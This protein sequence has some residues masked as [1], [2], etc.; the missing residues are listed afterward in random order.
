[1]LKKQYC[2]GILIICLF[3]Y[4]INPVFADDITYGN[5]YVE[6]ASY[7]AYVCNHTG[8]C[9]TTGDIIFAA[10]VIWN[11]DNATIYYDSRND[12]WE[13][14]NLT[15]RIPTCTPT[16]FLTSTDGSTFTCAESE[17]AVG[18]GLINFS[19]AYNAIT[20]RYDGDNYSTA[21]ASVTSALALKQDED[22]AWKDIN[23]TYN[24]TQEMIEAINQSLY[25]QIKVDWS[26]I[27]NRFI[28]AVSPAWFY[29]TG[30]TLTFNETKHNE[31]TDERITL[32]N[33]SIKTYV[34]D[35]NASQTAYTDLLNVT[36]HNWIVAQN[37][38]DNTVS[39]LINYFTKSQIFTF[40]EDNTTY[41]N[42]SMKDYTDLINRS[43]QEYINAQ[44]IIFNTSMKTYADSSNASQIGYTDAQD[45]IYNDSMVAHVDDNYYNITEIDNMDLYN[46]SEVND[47]IGQHNASMKNYVDVQDD[48]YNASMVDYYDR[49]TD[50]WQLINLTE[51]IPTCS[52]TQYLTSI[53]GL[54]FSCIESGEASDW[55]RANFSEAY[56]SI[57]DRWDLENETYNT[58]QDMINAVNQTG[59]FYDIKITW[60][61][62]IDKF[63]EAVDNV[64]INMDGTTATF[65]EAKLK[66][67]IDANITS[68]NESQNAYID[69]QDSNIRATAFKEENLTNATNWNK[70]GSDIYPSDLSGNVGIGTSSPDTLLDVEDN[71]V[72]LATIQTTATGAEYA[73]LDVKSPVGTWGLYTGAA[74]HTLIAGDFGIHDW[75]A[76]VYR[77]VIKDDGR[78][79]IG[80]SNPNRNLDIEGTGNVYMEIHSTDY[81]QFAI[82]SE[83]RG[84]VIYDDT[85][86]DYRMVIQ[87]GTGNVGIGTTSP[88]EKLEVAGNIN[89]NTNSLIWDDV[90]SFITSNRVAGRGSYGILIDS[91]NNDAGAQFTIGKD[92][93]TIGGQIELFRVEEGGNVGIGT[94]TPNAPLEIASTNARFRLND[95]DGTTFQVS[96]NTNIFSIADVSGG[97]AQI[98]KIE[99]GATANSIYIKSGGNV[100]I[101]NTIPNATLHVS[102]DVI[103]DNMKIGDVTIDSQSVYQPV[104]GTD[105][106]LVLYLPFNTPN[107]STQY[108]RSPYGNDGTQVGANCNSTNGKYGVGCGFDGVDDY[109]DVTDDA[110]L[111]SD[112]SDLTISA[113]IKL[114]A[115]ATNVKHGIISKRGTG[116][117]GYLLAYKQTGGNN[118]L[119]YE[120]YDGS[121]NPNEHSDTNLNLNQWY[122]IAITREPANDLTT[123]YLNGVNDGAETVD[124]ADDISN[125]GSLTIGYSTFTAGD[126]FNGTIDEVMI[127]KRALSAEEIRTHY[128]RG[129]GFG[130]S[131]A[132][133]A[134]KFRI[135]NTSGDVTFI[136]TDG[137]VGIGTPTPSSKLHVIG[138]IKAEK[139]NFTENV[140]VPYIFGKTIFPIVHADLVNKE[141]VDDAVSS[142]AFDFFFNDQASDISGHFNMTES[143]LDLPETTLT[144]A[145]LS[146]TGTFSI[147]NWTTL[148]GQPEFNELRKGVYG[149]HVHLGKSGSRTIAITP[150][151]YNISSDGTQRKLLVTFETSEEL[152]T[153]SLVYNLHGVMINDTILND[154]DRLNLELEAVVSSAGGGTTITVTLEGTTDSHLAV[155][156]STNAFE[157]IYVR[158]DGTNELTRNWNAGSFDI[159]AQNLFATSSIGIGTTSPNYEL[160]VA[161]QINAS[162][163]NVTGNIRVSSLSSCDTIDTDSEGNF[164]CGTDDDTTYTADETNI[165]LDGT[166]F[167][168]LQVDLAELDNSVSAF[169][170]NKVSN[171]VNYF[172]KTET[173]EHIGNNITSANESSNAK[174]YGGNVTGTFDA[175]VLNPCANGEI[176]KYSTTGKW[177]CSADNTGGAPDTSNY[178]NKANNDTANY[179]TQLSLNKSRGDVIGE[180]SSFF[181]S[182][183]KLFNFT[184]AYDGRIDRWDV[185][186][187]TYSQ[188]SDLTTALDDNYDPINSNPTNATITITNSQVSDFAAGVVANEQNPTNS[189]INHDGL[190]NFDLNEHFT[191]SS[192]EGILWKLSNFTTAFGNRLGELWNANNASNYLR[193]NSYL[194]KD[195]STIIA[196]LMQNDTINRSLYDLSQF[197]D[198]LTHTG[199]CSASNSCAAVVYGTNTT[200]VTSQSMGGDVGGTVGVSTVDDT[201]CTGSTEYLDGTGTCDDISGVYVQASDW[202]THDNYPSACT[203][204]FVRGLGD[205][206]TCA[207]VDSAD[208]AS[209]AVKDDEIDYSAVTLADF[210]NDPKFVS[211]STDVDFDNVTVRGNMSIGGHGIRVIGD[212]INW[213]IGTTYW[214]VG[215]GC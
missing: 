111:D 172:T 38:I 77:F 169:I 170:T 63:I 137:N 119:Y 57:G 185:G 14:I 142:T 161:G 99:A 153:D 101:G 211:N 55:G 152:T 2:F 205:S 114:A 184:K 23:E 133:T 68:A 84:F 82:G 187:E 16:Q 139:G 175:L 91:D 95:T 109:I 54:A 113:W 123:F 143:D 203:N 37:Y 200:Y 20:D 85:T 104:Y 118:R 46:G 165:T 10:S 97:G 107:G 34:D 81:S 27:L 93:T 135:V 158:R 88:S 18:W 98:F 40:F 44:D 140:S 21:N 190:L 207:T 25:Y 182:F 160:D 75:D 30:T 127:Y 87:N 151:L 128:L 80:T 197:N 31:T 7:S 50:R 163:V 138:D 206:L 191:Y 12:R 8:S 210:T 186:N 145:S 39:D 183:W 167:R 86:N 192:I 124:N 150:K 120:A 100:G 202:S 193:D 52:A 61:N 5:S 117:L 41:V 149:V 51:R 146:S 130:A 49:R 45:V 162:A 180:D 89:L 78:V 196:E 134:D 92:S 106:D 214:A 164:K 178:W 108:D 116:S 11:E 189:T 209:N 115:D 188:E 121:N 22:S 1:M 60:S 155:E 29:M 83:T 17:G 24:T 69:A 176:Y 201:K 19:E 47:S 70:T 110:S 147:F 177:V 102:G 157:K 213:T 94:T 194:T 159:T 208:I 13:L 26:N 132:I 73:G 136:V 141:Y 174:E 148:S 105:D 96:S 43:Q 4:L 199:N 90:N 156:T 212:C 15:E 28:T 36:Q 125:D 35:T 173:S 6:N 48:I 72:T 71:A 59:L 154:G 53:D 171:L 103:A 181:N 64:W 129:K 126:Y 179:L 166:V 56:D 79:G 62:I 195:N 3:L 42:D 198:D 67:Q 122:H 204:Q 65:N 76:G 215:S 168:L 33:E 131:G 112:N 66:E 58:T 9:S 144:S 32:H 74:G